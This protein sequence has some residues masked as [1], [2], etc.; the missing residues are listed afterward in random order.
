MQCTV[1]ANKLGLQLH[2]YFWERWRIIGSVQN[3]KGMDKQN[4]S[5]IIR[6]GFLTDKLKL[7]C[8]WK[9]STNTLL[10]HKRWSNLLE[11]VSEGGKVNTLYGQRSAKKIQTEMIIWFKNARKYYQV[12]RITDYFNEPSNITKCFRYTYKIWV[13]RHTRNKYFPI[14]W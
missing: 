8:H 6:A 4:Y 14:R 3:T 2:P 11:Y 5:G 7:R 9:S 1:N 13:L 10:L 12:H